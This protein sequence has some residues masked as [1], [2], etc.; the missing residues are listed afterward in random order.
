MKDLTKHWSSLSLS[1]RGGP[2]IHLKSEEAITEHGIVARFLTKR[3]LNIDAIAT[4]FTPLGRSKSGFKGKNIGDHII[5]FSVDNKTDVERILSSGPRSFNKHILVLSH[6]NKNS[7]VKAS[8]L[9]KVAFWVQV[10]DI[11]L[12]F[13]H[14]EIT[15]RICDPIGMILLPNEATDCDG[16]SFI[17]IRV[18]I[19]ISQLFVEVDS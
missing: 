6:Y 19:D 5:L 16:G 18:L 8:K 11:P 3:P 17:R 4:T 15:E 7:T 9:T 10:Y 1:E 13:S 14:R 12:C 2:S